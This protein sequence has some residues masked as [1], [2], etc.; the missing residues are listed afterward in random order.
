MKKEVNN[1]KTTLK[2]PFRGL[3]GNPYKKGA[4]FEGASHIIFENAKHLR[5]NM[6][7]AET[8]LWMHLKQGI[9]SCKFRRQ[10]P[11]RLYIADFYCHKARL[12]IETDG[13]IHNQPE[14]I[15]S[16]MVRQKDLIDWGYYVLRF[17]N[18]EVLH[19]PEKVL[20]IITEKLNELLNIQKQNASSKE[21]V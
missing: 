4:M 6:T 11:L 3:G 17:S 19:Q 5:K 13:A 8:V 12:I 2:T 21:G 9:S 10:H 15:E 1:S 18:Q 16:D 14:I 7:H 20:E